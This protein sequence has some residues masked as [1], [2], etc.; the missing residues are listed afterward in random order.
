[1]SLKYFKQHYADLT[2]KDKIDAINKAVPVRISEA[3]PEEIK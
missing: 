3:E 2:Y 1:M